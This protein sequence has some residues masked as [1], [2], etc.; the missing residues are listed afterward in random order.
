M[1]FFEALPDDDRYEGNYLIDA[2]HK[3]SMPGVACPVCKFTGSVLGIAYPNFRLPPE[4]DTKPYEVAWPVTPARI[5][6]LTIPFQV[7]QAQGLPV[8]AGTE[9][10]PLIGKASGKFGDVTW[11][12]EWTPLV[13]EEG[14]AGLSRHGISGLK[15]VAPEIELRSKN[16]KFEH[17]E[18]SIDPLVH[19]YAPNAERRCEECGIPLDSEAETLE[20]YRPVILENTF[21]KGLHLA[22]V[23]ESPAYIVASEEFVYGTTELGLTDIKFEELEVR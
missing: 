1:R 11:L 8:L 10:G 13:S 4:I 12:N 3:W 9:F 19:A 14:L 5:R 18:L 22:R 23:I 17:L 20:P 2:T 6:E 7:L 15:V 21:P 16:R